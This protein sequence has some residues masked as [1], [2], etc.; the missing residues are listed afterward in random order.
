MASI[1]RNGDAVKGSR[2][3]LHRQS[4]RCDDATLLE[5]PAAPPIMAM[6]DRSVGQ[7]VDHGSFS[8]SSWRL[9]VQK[10]D[11]QSPQALFSPIERWN[12]Q[13]AG[14]TLYESDILQSEK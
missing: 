14:R 2:P 12:S 11:V 4:R 7:D 13:M 6:P 5:R 10:G 8:G 9:P 3:G 1:V